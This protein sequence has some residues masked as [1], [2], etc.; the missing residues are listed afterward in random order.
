[1]NPVCLELVANTKSS[2][3]NGLLQIHA[4]STIIDV[5][6][7]LAHHKGMQ[8]QQLTVM[9]LSMGMMSKPDLVCLPSID[10]IF[11]IHNLV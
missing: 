2:T 11:L 7:T 6:A 5:D 8:P 3:T 4:S 10:I 1:L 9:T